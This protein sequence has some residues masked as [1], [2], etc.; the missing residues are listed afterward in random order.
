MT[1]RDFEMLTYNYPT[2]DEYDYGEKYD[3]E[4]CHD[5]MSV[6]ET[7]TPSEEQV[8]IMRFGLDSEPPM[9][10]KQVSV[11]LNRT[12]YRVAKIQQRTLR[13]LKYRQQLLRKN[14]RGK[15]IPNWV[16]SNTMR[17]YS[18]IE[19]TENPTN[20]IINTVPLPWRS[21][22]DDLQAFEEQL[23]N[24]NYRSIL[25]TIGYDS[26]LLDEERYAVIRYAVYTCGLEKIEKKLRM[27]ISTSR[28]EKQEVY[29]SDLRFLEE[30]KECQSCKQGE[31]Y[32]Y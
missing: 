3:L 10:E 12:K 22:T 6:L 32:I 28:G 23:K 11:F 17:E 26:K 5:I 31:E 9:T 2:K 27:I 29:M 16:W 8:L 13:K 21:K 24:G 15:P 30:D 14:Y 1:N 18:S 19:E 7:L 25:K 4:Y 20:D